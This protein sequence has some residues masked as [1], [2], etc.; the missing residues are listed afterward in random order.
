MEGRNTAVATPNTQ[1]VP[2]LGKVCT[3]MGTTTAAVDLEKTVAEALA[4]CEDLRASEQMARLDRHFRSEVFS[5][6]AVATID[7]SLEILESVGIEKHAC[8]VGELAPDFLLPDVHGRQV[9]LSSLWERG[10]VVLTFFRGAWCPCCNIQL[11]ALEKS[12]PRI[13]ELGASLVAV[14]PE[15][16]DHSLTLSQKGKFD[17]QILCDRGNQ[18]ARKFGLVYRVGPGMLRRNTDA[19]I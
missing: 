17:F 7:K 5:P 12:W 19:T 16:L 4:G 6:E 2:P 10:P 8:K 13:K 9:S 18:A 3:A 15:I 11:R 14:S 1:F